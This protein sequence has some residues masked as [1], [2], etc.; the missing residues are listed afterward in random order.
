[1]AATL[2]SMEFWVVMPCSSEKSRY[3]RGKYFLSFSGLNIKLSENLAEAGCS[4]EVQVEFLS[5]T[6]GFL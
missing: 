2:K 6:L 4:R 1:M 5:E 3:F